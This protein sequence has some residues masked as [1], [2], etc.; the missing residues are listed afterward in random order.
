MKIN[1]CLKSRLLA[2]GEKRV[3]YGV[4]FKGRAQQYIPTKLSVNKKHWDNK[5]KKVSQNHSSWDLINQTLA[6]MQKKA[7]DL[8]RRYN[9]GKLT[10]IGVINKLKGR[11][12][13]SSLD[14]FVETFIKS[15]MKEVTYKSY[16]NNLNSFKKAL[17]IKGKMKFSDID[18]STMSRFHRV[19]NKRIEQG[20]WTKKTATS[21]AQIIRTI[22][23]FAFDEDA[24]P[25]KISF[26]NKHKKFNQSYKRG[27]E[28]YAPNGKDIYRLIDNVDNIKHWQSIAFWLLCFSMRGL[29]QSDIVK[30]S[31]ELLLDKNLKSLEN[32]FIDDNAYLD[33]GRS[34]NNMPMF[35]RLYPVILSLIRR[36]K[37][38]VIY[39][40]YGRK[41][42]GREI[43]T[44]IEN[45]INIF[46]YNVSENTNSH[47]ELWR[48]FGDNF[49]KLGNKKIT[50]KTARKSF[51]QQAEQ[52]FDYSTAQKL[53]GQKLKGVGSEF[54]SN[55][56]SKEQIDK[57][58]E[59]HFQ[60]LYKIKFHHLY[61][62]LIRKLEWLIERDT[63]AKTK[64]APK[65][66]LMNGGI[67]KVGNKY[68][69]LTGQNNKLVH[70]DIDS[71]FI[72]YFKAP[73]EVDVDI[74]DD[75]YKRTIKHLA[76]LNVSEVLIKALQ[77]DMKDLEKS[78]S[79]RSIRDYDSLVATK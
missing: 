17:D 34:K 31:D 32:K 53:T 21:Y 1:I 58:D 68:K 14:D 77:K 30:L 20:K 8:E 45:R 78:R 5:R 52:L 70:I 37:Y 26:K 15:E 76:K 73:K 35:I 18:N 4:T 38:S 13:N 36:L 33:Y 74:E 54:Y 23:E 7:S 75:T 46:D 28:N 67:H 51:F 47:R 72:K 9:L 10:D 64:T 42:D 22:C 69:M 43:T 12:D 66:L 62:I 24:I 16:V 61:H 63:R 60:V 19:G 65:W 27:G 44:G 57:I 55:Y 40:Q 29:Y 3:L 71:K 25:E 79:V 6:E 2:N 48:T 39:T 11:N 49:K 41:I 56:K 50:L 59:Q